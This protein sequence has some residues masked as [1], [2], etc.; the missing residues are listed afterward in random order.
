MSMR[1]DRVRAVK[2]SKHRPS[3]PHH[4]LTTARVGRYGILYTIYIRR[5]GTKIT[6]LTPWILHPTR[7]TGSQTHKITG[8]QVTGS[9]TTDSQIHRLTGSQGHRLTIYTLAP[10]ITGSQAHQVT[11]SPEPQVTGSPDHR[12]QGHGSQV[13]ESP[14]HKPQGH[15]STRPQAHQ[16]TRPQVTG[17]PSH[18]ITG[19]RVTGHRVTGSQTTSSQTHRLTRCHGLIG[20]LD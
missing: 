18:R 8:L 14:D 13:T 4:I 10:W 17:S 12:S 1:K 3:P 16:T 7:I 6:T 19:S 20:S 2:W 5:Y 9:Q 11:G 15:Q